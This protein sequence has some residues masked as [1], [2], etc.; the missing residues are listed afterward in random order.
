MESRRRMAA[1]L[2]ILV[3]IIAPLLPTGAALGEGISP[4]KKSTA[5]TTRTTPAKTTPEMKKIE[6]GPVS[7]RRLLPDLVVERIDLTEDCH[8]SVTVKNQGPGP[9][10]D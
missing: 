2:A 5:D 10:P 3:F 4:V 6:T 8:V 7:E 9:V 1:G